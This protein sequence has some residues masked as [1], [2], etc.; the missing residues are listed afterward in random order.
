[1]ELIV[2]K[3]A[4][5]RRQVS[6]FRIGFCGACPRLRSWFTA[7]KH[8][9][10]HAEIMEAL[11]I[12]GPAI[13]DAVVA[14]DKVPNLPPID[15]DTAESA[16]DRSRLRLHLPW[17]TIDSLPVIRSRTGDLDAKRW[18]LA[19]ADQCAAVFSAR[20]RWITTESL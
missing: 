2:V 14:V 1:M 3:H 13:V 9:Q 20:M 18:S 12:D 15:L 6:N 11:K 5:M 19:P 4:L 17:S 7:R 10:R 8:G 16:G